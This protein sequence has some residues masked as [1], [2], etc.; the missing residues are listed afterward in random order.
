MTSE[1]H[2]VFR[3]EYLDLPTDLFE[4]LKSDIDN[5]R[6][7]QS[8]FGYTPEHHNNIK[9]KVRQWFEKL[10]FRK[11]YLRLH[12]L[13]SE[14]EQLVL[15]YYQDFINFVNSPYKL[16]Y[17]TIGETR[18]IPPHSDV[19]ISERVTG[20]AGNGDRTSMFIVIQGNNE[21]TNWFSYPGKFQ[22]GK[23]FNPFKLKRQV[24]K[25]LEVGKCYL[26]NTEAIHSVSNCNPN[27]QRWILTIC[28]NN[29][30]HTELCNLYNEFVKQK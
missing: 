15:A 18:W 26:F 5:N 2:Y 19:E 29:I 1:S 28:W 21:T 13:D 12:K 23:W 22:F 4:L 10:L 8:N 27:K 14:S 11:G 30:S 7:Q 9:S 16:R 24:S 3:A 17:K 25:Q 20:L 6:Y